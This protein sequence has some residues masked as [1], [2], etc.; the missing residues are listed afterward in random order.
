MGTPSLFLATLTG[1][2][3]IASSL[4]SSEASRDVTAHPAFLL[5]AREDMRDAV[6]GR[7]RFKSLS[8]SIADI[9]P[10]AMQIWLSFLFHK[11]P[12]FEEGGAEIQPMGYIFGWQKCKRVHTLPLLPCVIIVLRFE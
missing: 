12:Y 6:Y 5:A 3:V 2:E 9:Q 7:P 8:N 4:V 10:E 1:T 11:D